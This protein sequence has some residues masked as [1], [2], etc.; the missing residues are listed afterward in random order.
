MINKGNT[1]QTILVLL[2]ITVTILSTISLVLITG[3][4]TKFAQEKYPWHIWYEARYEN[5][6]DFSS[7]IP[8][9]QCENVSYEV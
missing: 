8:I 2:V 5:K 3:T 4:Y 1:K 7:I 6:L 9:L